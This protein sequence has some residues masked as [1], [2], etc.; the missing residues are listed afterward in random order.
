MLFNSKFSIAL[1]ADIMG[2]LWPIAYIT[3]NNVVDIFQAF[4]RR[5][6]PL[7]RVCNFLLWR[8]QHNYFKFKEGLQKGPIPDDSRNAGARISVNG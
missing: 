7:A 8:G 3:A 6:H 5:S 4:I 1:P 2:E